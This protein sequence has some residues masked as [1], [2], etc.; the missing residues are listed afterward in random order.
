MKRLKSMMLAGFALAALVGLTPLARAQNYEYAT[1]LTIASLAT[2]ITN[3]ATSNYTAV[4]NVKK[5]DTVGIFTKFQLNGAGS[6]GNIIKFSKSVDG[7][8]FETTPSILITNVSN[9]TTPAYYFNSVSVAGAAAIR[10]ESVV[11]GSAA[12]LTNVLIQVGIP[13]R[14]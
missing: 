4:V 13:A 8:N 10:L 1:P 6:S 7:S 11:N 9:G 5:A 2:T 12:A 14:R 3:S